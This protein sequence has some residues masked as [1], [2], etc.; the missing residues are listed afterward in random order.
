MTTSSRYGVPVTVIWPE[1]DNDDNFEYE[2]AITVAEYSGA[3]EIAQ[4]GKT[5]NVP[6]YAIAEL[7]RALRRALRE[8]A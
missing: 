3:V 2:H 8:Q 4:N 1:H 7:V 6:H 5:I